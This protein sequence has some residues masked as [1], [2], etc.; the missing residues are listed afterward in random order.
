MMGRTLWQ[1]VGKWVRGLWSKDEGIQELM[2]YNG[3]AASYHCP[4]HKTLITSLAHTQTA[5][6]FASVSE[7]RLLAEK[8]LQQW[9]AYVTARSLSIPAEH[10][11]SDLTQRRLKR[12]WGRLATEDGTLAGKQLQE[13][14]FTYWTCYLDRPLVDA[15]SFEEM[16][17][18]RKA[19]LARIPT[20]FTYPKFLSFLKIQSLASFERLS[21]ENLLAKQLSAYNYWIC[22][23]S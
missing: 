7:K 4:E 17:G 14:L 20:A 18:M 1:K 10:R 11:L 3:L 23:D 15:Q 19:Y 6:T 2:E 22:F 21:G 8:E 9:K 12:L 13:F 16:E 5:Y